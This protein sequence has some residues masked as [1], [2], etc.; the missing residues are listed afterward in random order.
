M[1]LLQLELKTK[2]YAKKPT[3]IRAKGYWKV[4][5]RYRGHTENI[6]NV[7]SR[8]EAKILLSDHFRLYRQRFGQ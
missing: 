6:V 4:F 1:N 7:M 2:W 3:I 5:T 8:D